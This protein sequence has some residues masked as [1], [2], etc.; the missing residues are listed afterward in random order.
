V[1]GGIIG[2]LPD[3]PYR[4]QLGAEFFKRFTLDGR[5]IATVFGELCRQF[6]EYLNQSQLRGLV[7][8][9]T[10]FLHNRRVGVL[11]EY[12]MVLVSSHI[13]NANPL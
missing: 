1:V 5:H 2:F 13:I 8:L 10:H 3:A 11:V 12:V 4:E 9:A 6:S 7:A